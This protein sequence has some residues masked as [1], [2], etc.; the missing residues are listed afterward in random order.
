MR[1]AQQRTYGGFGG[2]GYGSGGSFFGRMG[3]GSRNPVYW[4]IGINVGAF[5]VYHTAAQSDPALRRWFSR[6]M[7]VSQSRVREGHYGCI[8][9]SAFFHKDPLHLAFNMFTLYSFGQTAH[10]MLGTRAFLGL[11][12]AA[13]IGGS[14]AHL[15][16]PSLVRRFDMP[17][18]YRVHWDQSGV[19][20][21]GAI[22]GLIMYVC[23]RIPQGEMLLMF[24]PLKNWLFVPLFL[25]GSGYAAYS[26]SDTRLGHAAH[27]GGAAVGL[28]LYFAR[29]GRF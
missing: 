20:A 29:R 24:I 12:L 9:G 3:H 8:L 5:L 13:G 14:L 15:A 18:R 7:V 2:S 1:Q 6:N 27:L 21:S 26:G 25:L 23:S 17:A 4:L 28:A 11:Y 16:Y 10:M 22:A 19:G